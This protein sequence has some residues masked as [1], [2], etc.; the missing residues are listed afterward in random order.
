[1]QRK[2]FGLKIVVVTSALLSAVPTTLA[3]TCGYL[4]PASKC[5]GCVD[6]L[7]T[8][9]CQCISGSCKNAFGGTPVPAVA[10]QTTNWSYTYDSEGDLLCEESALCQL[11]TYCS[12]ALPVACNSSFNPCEVHTAS[13][14]ATKWVVV[15]PDG[16]NCGE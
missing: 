15:L 7:G 5:P 6:Q 10:C 12:A 11:T 16:V 2:L 14:Y 13:I 9:G 4:N 3:C 1:M 8:Y